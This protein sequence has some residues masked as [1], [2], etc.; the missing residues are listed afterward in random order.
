MVGWV[1]GWEEETETEREVEV[2]LWRRCGGWWVVVWL[3]MWIRGWCGEVWWR[4]G[5][6][7]FVVV[8]RSVGRWVV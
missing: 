5:G 1:N 7:G 3:G 4:V 8:N 6:C 2:E